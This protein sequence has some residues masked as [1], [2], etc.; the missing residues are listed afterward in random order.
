MLG[1]CARGSYSQVFPGQLSG[2]E[3]EICISPPPAT[4]PLSLSNPQA[5]SLALAKLFP[6][7]GP[8][9]SHV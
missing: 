1:V 6:L 3:K 7:S 4:P 5:L 8:P 2:A 9:F